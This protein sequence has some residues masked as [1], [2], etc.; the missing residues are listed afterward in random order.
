M[1]A[2]STFT[3]DINHVHIIFQQIGGKRKQ[4]VTEFSRVLCKCHNQLVT[5]LLREI[6]SRHKIF[7]PTPR[8]VR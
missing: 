1:K 6:I 3:S 2:D 8:G 7:F 4:T 5:F